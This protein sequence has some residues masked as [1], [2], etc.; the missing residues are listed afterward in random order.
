MR[1]FESARTELVV[2]E[3]FEEFKSV[4]VYYCT[5]VPH[6]PHRSCYLLLDGESPAPPLAA[7]WSRLQLRVD[8]PLLLGRGLFTCGHP[9]VSLCDNVSEHF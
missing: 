7:L 5:S 9:P 2:V 3:I 1:N 8:G 6:S 4:E